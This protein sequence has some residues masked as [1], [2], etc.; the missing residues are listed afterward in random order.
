MSKPLL[1]TLLLGL[2]LI[3]LLAP[4]SGLALLMVVL[5]VSAFLWTTWTLIQV[6]ISGNASD[7]N[8][9]ASEKG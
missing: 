5:F 4:F 7:M 9:N 2:L 1:T 3:T 6:F 8:R